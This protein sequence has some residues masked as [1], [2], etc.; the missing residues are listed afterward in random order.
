[1]GP[2][3]HRRERERHGRADRWRADLARLR[4]D[5]RELL[6]G[7]PRGITYQCA[8][9]KVPQDWTAQADGKTFDIALLRARSSRQSDRI[10]SLLINP[11]GPGGSGVDYAVYLSQLPGLNSRFDVVGFDPRG[12]GRSTQVKCMTDQQLDTLFGYDPDPVSKADFDKFVAVN[13]EVSDACSAKYGESL[14]LFSTVQTARD[15][16][17][18]RAAVGDPKT[19]Y[20]GYS[21]GTLLGGVYAQLFPTNIRAMVLDGAIDPAEQSEARSRGRPRASSAPSTTSRSGASRPRPAAPWRPTRAPWC[22]R[23]WPPRG[24]RRKPAP[25]AGWPPRAGSSRRSS[26]RCT[27][28]TTGRSSARPSTT[29]ATATRRPSSPSPTATPNGTRTVTTPTCST[30]TPR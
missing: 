6:G 3:A 9:I 29:C 5:P 21:Y 8:T 11:G 19:T 18:V 4:R 15:M 14:R 2:A 20:L 13:R 16:D 23:S 25:A 26:R 24:P 28:R 22:R 12:V 10:G 7:V 30:R 1:M 17:A 27:S